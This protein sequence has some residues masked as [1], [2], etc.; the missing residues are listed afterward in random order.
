MKTI[1]KFIYLRV[2]LIFCMK[3]FTI[4]LSAIFMTLI[5]SSVQSVTADDAKAEGWLG[6]GIGKYMRQ[7][8]EELFISS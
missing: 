2:N 3:R 6:A 1:G 4:C 8:E 5:I 7:K